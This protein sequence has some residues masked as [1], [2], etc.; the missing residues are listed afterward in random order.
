[1]MSFAS[2]VLRAA[3]DPTKSPDGALG[4]LVFLVLAVVV[5]FLFRSMNKH[6][7]KVQRIK[8]DEQ[9]PNASG[10]SA[11]KPRKPRPN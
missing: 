6:L 9:D 2:P 3:A 5:Y 10:S 4:L 8:F 7:R 11:A 1:M